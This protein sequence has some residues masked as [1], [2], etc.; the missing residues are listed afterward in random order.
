[1]RSATARALLASAVVACGLAWEPAASADPTVLLASRWP[2]VP[3]GHALTLEDQIVER[4][5]LLGNTLGQH[6]DLLSHD[7]VQLRVDARRRR[8]HLQIGG[9]DSDGLSLRLHS[10][11]QFD[12]LNA[13]VCARLDVALRGHAVQL[14]LPTFEMSPVS[15]RGDHGVEFRVPLFIQ[16]F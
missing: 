11:I 5:T 10:D 6:L 3:D 16:Q 15:Y 8:A 4:L 14:E 1:M 9:G 12:D 2:S 13:R 7:F